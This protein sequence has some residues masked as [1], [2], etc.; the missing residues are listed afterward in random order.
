MQGRDLFFFWKKEKNVYPV[1]IKISQ[2]FQI[3]V[4]P[5]TVN[6]GCERALY[7][8]RLWSRLMRLVANIF[9]NRNNNCHFFISGPLLIYFNII[10]FQA[11]TYSTIAMV[12]FLFQKEIL[13]WK[14]CPNYF[15][16]WS[17][18]IQITIPIWYSFFSS[19]TLK[20]KQYIVTV[21]NK[22]CLCQTWSI[23]A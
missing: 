1:S 19:S 20:S 4:F 14:D 21:G 6:S 7:D 15:F 17:T 23:I 9:T 13:F 8:W 18:N 16:K 10:L 12:Y 5:V 3:I 22:K 2:I 11:H